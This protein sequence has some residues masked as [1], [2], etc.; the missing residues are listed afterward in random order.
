[1]SDVHVRDVETLIEQNKAMIEMMRTQ[2]DKCEI[3][4]PSNLAKEPAEIQQ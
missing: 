3:P 2:S 4:D 1:M